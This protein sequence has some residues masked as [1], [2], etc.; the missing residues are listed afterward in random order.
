MSTETFAVA[1][2]GETDAGW[3][4][5]AE[6]A[7]DAISIVHGTVPRAHVREPSHQVE[8]ADRPFGGGAVRVA[9]VVSSSVSLSS[10]PNAVASSQP[11]SHARG[12]RRA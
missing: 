7:E 6:S 5:D 1:L 11:S 2:V 3:L 4:V 9:H 8:A 10:S 12:L